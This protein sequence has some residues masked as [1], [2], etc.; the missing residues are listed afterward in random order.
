[1]NPTAIAC[2]SYRTFEELELHL[3]EGALA[4]TGSM[5]SGKSSIVEAIELALYG[6][7][8]TGA[9]SD[10][11][12]IGFD[13]RLEITLTFE[14]DGE[15]YRARRGYSAAGRGK[16]TLDLEREE[17]TN[18]GN[19]G[20]RTLSADF[21]PL[22][23][24]S[25]RATQQA[26]EELIG[27]SHD[28][29]RASCFIAQKDASAF[30]NASP[31][32]AKAILGEV[33]RLG[34]WDRLR[35]VNR[36]RKRTV[37]REGEQLAGRIALLEESAGSLDELE[38]TRATIAQGVLAAELAHGDAEKKLTA[39][40]ETVQEIERI[41][42]RYVAASSQLSASEARFRERQ[43]VIDRAATAKL[44]A[45][46]VQRE[47]SEA[48][49]PSARL[50]ELEERRVAMEAQR[51]LRRQAEAERARLETEYQADVR[52]LEALDREREGLSGKCSEILETIARLGQS[53]THRCD[54]CEQELHAESLERA[55]A[56]LRAEHMSHGERVSEI[57]AAMADLQRHAKKITYAAGLIEVPDAPHSEEQAA[58]VAEI[59]TVRQAEL[60]LAGL[61]QKLAGLEAQVT[62]VTPSLSAEVAGLALEVVAAQEALAAIEE[63]EPGALDG[64]RVAAVTA[65]AELD[66]ASHRLTETRAAL[67][68][69]ESALEAAQKIAGELRSARG[70][71][72]ELLG[73]LDLLALLERAYGRDGIPALIVETL[74]IPAIE[75]EANR[76]LAA[77]GESNRVELR[78]QAE[79][80]SG[81][82]LKDGLWI[83]VQTPE[84][85][86][87][88]RTFSGGEGACL[89]F[90]LRVG[91]ARLLRHRAGADISFLVVDELEGL[92]EA[93]QAAFVEIILGLR[94][95]F[96][97][98]MISSHYSGLRDAPLDA[99]IEVV[100]ED[101]RSRI[102]G[103]REAVLV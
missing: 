95:E 78:T 45:V 49:S 54:R 93:R 68:R 50:A 55:L 25:I 91:L 57:D 46:P 60:V 21:V 51:E 34:A 43:A 44:E 14:H 75:R 23:R 59:Q 67:V 9:L 33:M 84:G 85:E 89:D 87:G 47:L 102:V 5:G 96:S 24:E 70:R 74:A 31:A 53:G 4:V 40:A 56:S 15:T 29:F 20:S 58:L 103:D 37:E 52:Q 36:E 79:R 94:D 19:G 88:H 27:L 83:V 17:L 76:I 99:L 77:F 38:A 8:R 97:K 80:K 82:G 69:A 26:I 6:S 12:G 92:D 13:D 65:K 28:S 61:R 71:E 22:T 63:P 7:C 16:P 81:D 41:A 3:P 10:N 86:R 73:E 39:A 32:D 48:G 2:R 62:E 18:P 11:L 35:D 42:A 1:M 72:Q 30:T 101:G 100:N 66:I 64:Q 90:A 98:I